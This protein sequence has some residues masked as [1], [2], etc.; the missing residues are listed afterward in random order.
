MQDTDDMYRRLSIVSLELEGLGLRHEANRQVM[1]RQL[2]NGWDT[3]ALQV[4]VEVIEPLKIYDRNQGDTLYT[5]FS[6]LT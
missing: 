3:H 6:P 5:V 1:M 4:L 2:A